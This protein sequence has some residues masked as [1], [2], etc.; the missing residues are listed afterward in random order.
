MVMSLG[1]LDMAG[2]ALGTASS[3]LLL[4]SII[5][6][7]QDVEVFHY[8]KMDA[9]VGQN[10]ILPCTIRNPEI[11]TTIIEWKKMPDE[12][13]VVH[14][15]A[16]GSNYIWPNVTILTQTESLGSLKLSKVTKWDSGVYVCDL[17]TFPNG[18]IRRE[19]TLVIKD[20]E[21]MCDADGTIEIS[22]GGNVSIQ[23]AV[24]P[25]AQYS[26][27]KNTAVVSVSESLELWK[28]TEAH[29]GVYILTVNTGSISVQKEFIITL[30]TETTSPSTDLA[31]LSPH[32]NGTEAHLIQTTSNTLTTSST[33]ELQAISTT[34][35][36]TTSN[37]TANN[38][39]PNNVTTPYT[40]DTHITVTSTS[41]LYDFT[42]SSYQ[43]LNQTHSLSTSTSEARNL[44]PTLNY[45]NIS[46][47]PTQETRN[48]SNR[49]TTVD[50]G[51]TGATP[52][53][54]TGNETVVT[55]DEETEGVRSHLLSVLI[56]VLF[57]VLII[58]AV[59]LYRRHIIKQR[60]DLPP[61]FKPPPPPVKYTAARRDIYTQPYP[62]SRCNSVTEHADVKQNYVV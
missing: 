3:L 51:H 40:I 18:A 61:P 17:S 36:W 31:T 24:L 43:E 26:W 9:L 49:G 39:H 14:S 45:S 23:C 19:T 50:T 54:S 20:V 27:T 11:R 47:S 44:S 1:S 57:L 62:T 22:I 10:V 25:N 46:F 52:T 13:L 42:N 6:G 12:K 34:L 15:P 30:L 53:Q 5:Q 35:P 4:A 16:Y 56:I 41:G 2:S 7:L 48:E 60:M 29:T 33:T 58:V 28:V 8:E 21:T 32:S 38:S 55:E 37:L 59:F